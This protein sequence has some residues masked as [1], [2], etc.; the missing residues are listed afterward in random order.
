MLQK[1]AICKKPELWEKELAKRNMVINVNKGHGSRR[2]RRLTINK[3]KT[4]KGIF[5]VFGSVDR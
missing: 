2:T 4:E 3:Q 1:R 5:L